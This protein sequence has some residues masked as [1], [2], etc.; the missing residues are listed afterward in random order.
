MTTTLD[1]EYKY[2]I[3]LPAGDIVMLPFTLAKKNTTYPAHCIFDHEEPAATI[4]RTH[5]C[6]QCTEWLRES[7]N[8]ISEHWPDL[9]DALAPS[10]G[11]AASSE[12]VSG[13]G[14]LFPPL[15]INGD[16]S[17]VMRDTRNAIWSTVGQLVQ[18]RPDLRMPADH[19]TGV[20][21]DWLARWHVGYLASHPS[22]AHL[23]AVG[24]DLAKVVPAVKSAA[25]QSPPVEVSLDI[26][27]HHEGCRGE[28]VA[29]ET[30][31][32]RKVVRCSE[33]ITHRVA[34]DQWFYT[35]ANSR[36][37][38]ASSALKKKYLKAR[39]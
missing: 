15:P 17:D 12:R 14:D 33:N 28:V 34:A 10:G 16:V 22:A 25:Y 8:S 3:E 37:G 36:P 21:A 7:L 19:G 31:A 32:G 4:D 27:C 18:D 20:L 26:A 9:E 30:P 24:T 2:R 35:H 11:R 39:Q 5:L 1:L 6:W 29:T 38:R 23:T 13:T